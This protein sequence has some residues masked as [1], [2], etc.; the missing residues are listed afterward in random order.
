M[1][2][3][4][5]ATTSWVDY[6]VPAGS[7]IVFSIKQFRSGSGCQCEERTNTL[8]KTFIS[9]NT[10]D[11]MYDW[12]IG[13][14]IDQLLNDAIVTASCGEP[15]PV[16]TFI[17]GYTVST[18]P[19]ALGINYYQFYRNPTTNELYLMITGTI[20]CPGWGYPLSRASNVEVNIT[21][22]RS[23]KNLIFETEPTDALPDVFF[24]NEM[25]FAITGGNHMGNLQKPK[26]RSRNICYN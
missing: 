20:S 17:P 13:D 6:T 25:S 16:N 4:D 24:E 14:N 3:Y 22:F 18:I 19:T 2:T 23:E 12:W 9:S 7:R 26:Y 11:N 8:E 10:Y 1:N 15:L 21:V 5:A